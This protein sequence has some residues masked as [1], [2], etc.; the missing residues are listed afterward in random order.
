MTRDDYIFVGLR[1]LG[2]WLAILAFREG[3]IL[4]GDSM[5]M[6]TL[7][8]VSDEALVEMNQSREYFH[9]NFMS[10]I[11]AAAVKFAGLSIGS[12]YLIRRGAAL[13]VWMTPTARDSDAV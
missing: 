1:L 8:N 4:L 12:W 11:G 2:V 6:S 7:W 10:R 5:M 9:Q 13:V 3:L